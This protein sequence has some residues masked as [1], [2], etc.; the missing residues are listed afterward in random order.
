L[1]SE[2]SKKDDVGEAVLNACN[3][4]L[5]RQASIQSPVEKNVDL[6]ELLLRRMLEKIPE[7]IPDRYKEILA[8]WPRM[9][10][11]ETDPSQM[12]ESEERLKKAYP[13]HPDLLD[14]FFG[15]WAELHQFHEQGGSYK[16]LPWPCAMLNLGTNLL[17]SARRSSSVHRTKTGLS[18]PCSRSRRR[19]MDS[20]TGPT[21][22]PLAGELAN[23]IAQGKGGPEVRCSDTDGTGD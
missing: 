12:P 18:E 2:P 1:A 11:W 21:Q 10:A 13:F 3:S 8:F 5:G 16:P 15:K 17:S 4:G 7:S 20:V 23:G 6:A 22:P 14:R 9:A 19:A